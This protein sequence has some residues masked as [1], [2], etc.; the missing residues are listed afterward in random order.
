MNGEHH[1]TFSIATLILILIYMGFN[2]MKNPQS[3]T[4]I[5]LWLIGTFIITCDLDTNSRSR[6]R[7]GPVGWIIDKIFPH[8]GILHSVKFWVFVGLVGYAVIEWPISGLI[9]P[10]FLHIIT[11]YLSTTYKTTVGEI[12]R[13]IFG[14]KRCQKH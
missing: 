9:I 13:K 5:L 14:D 12:K 10:Q 6:K 4:F 3:Q 2:W 1:E 7:L 11:D 8:R